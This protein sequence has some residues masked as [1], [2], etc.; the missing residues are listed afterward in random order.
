MKKSIR[1][2]ISLLLT[3]TLL[4]TCLSVP[5][6][7]E[8][9]VSGTPITGLEG[10]YKTQG[11]TPIVGDTLMLDWTASGIEWEAN[12]SGDVKVTLNAT[13]MGHTDVDADGGL[14]FTVYVD[15]VMQAADLRMPETV[16]SIWTSN[17]TDYPFHITALGDTTFTIA[18]GL[19]EGK[20]TFAIY[21]QTEANMGAFGV[22]SIDLT[23]EFLDAPAD[24]E[25]YVEFVGDSITAGH[26]VL[27]NFDVNAPLYEDATRG[28]P[29]LT[30]KALGADW[31][32]LAV[33]G[34]TAID[35]I[36][37][38]G[39]GSVSMQDVYPY[40]IYYSDKTTTHDFANSREPDVIVL[41][42]GTNDCWTWNGTGGVTLTDDQKVT[43][44][45]TML[46]HLRDRNPNAK[47]VWVYG[48]MSSAADSYI[49]QAVSEMGGVGNGYYTLGLEKNT[50]GGRG[51]PNLAVQTTYAADVSSFITKITTPVEQEDWEVPTEKPAYI[52][53]GTSAD[54]YLITNGAE[55]YWAVTNEN[56]GVYFK[57]ANDIILNEMTVDAANGLVSSDVALKEW[58]TDGDDGV[59]F[60]GTIDGD[61]H[62]IKGLYIDHEYTGTTKEWNMGYGLISHANGAVIKNL[63]IESAYVKVVGGAAAAFVGSI[64]NNVGN[65]S[66]ENCYV[67][68][69]VY[70]CGN[71]AG[72]FLSSGGGSKL[73]GGVKNCY[74]I[75][76]VVRTN[77]TYNC[78]GI[79]GPIWSMSSSNFVENAY[80]I[81]LLNGMGTVTN[82]TNVFTT[83]EQTGCTSVTAANMQGT[84]GQ[85]N[86]K[87]LSENF[88]MVDSGYPKL[89]TFVG[90]TNGEWSGFRNDGMTGSGT[91]ASP[92]ILKTPEQLAQIIYNGGANYYFRLENDIYLNDPE[93]FDWATGTVDADYTTI[94]W[95]GFTFKGHFDGNGHVVYGLY[96][97]ETTNN[98]EWKGTGDALFPAMSAGSIKNVGVDHSFIQATNNAAAIVGYAGSNAERTIDNC[99]AGAHVTLIGYNAGGIYGSGDAN[100]TITNC[101][102]LATL[103]GGRFGGISGGW[104]SYKYND[105]YTAHKI[106]NCYTTSSKLYHSATSQTNC[107][108]GVSAKGDAA[109]NTYGNL[110][111]AYVR[112]GENFPTLKV[113]TDLPENAPWN[114]FGD[115]SYIVDGAGTEENPY[116]IETAAQLAHVIY[117]NGGKYY[118]LA[119]DIY[120]NDVSDGWLDREDNLSWV[121]SP[122]YNGYGAG[123][124][125][126]SGTLDGDG[127]VVYGLFYPDDTTAYAGSL[128]PLMGSG[129][130]KNIGVKNSY[131]VARDTASG[132]VG[133][134]RPGSM[135]TVENCFADDTVSAKWTDSSMNGGAAGIVGYTSNGASAH[136]VTIKNCWSAASLTSA[137]DHT[138][139][140]NGIIGKSWVAYY[141]IENCYSIGYKPF[142]INSEKTISALGVSAYKG[143]YTDS[144]TVPYTAGTYTNLTTAQM[145]GKDALTAMSGL[146]GDT[147]YAVDGKTPYLRSYGIT[148]GDVD[149]DGAYNKESDIVALRKGI[150]GVVSAKNGDTDKNGTVDICDLVKFNN[151]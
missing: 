29:Y 138:F 42:L 53:S 41:G 83:V 135:K 48:M 9:T 64:G 109:I 149:E 70:L 125:Y 62:V 131:I 88:C 78:G 54:P 50:A 79:Y 127:Y 111:D 45:K 43:G 46:T 123:D 142:G 137:K 55:L 18:T 3:I 51:H 66:F 76:T 130:V 117:N 86:L 84:A 33:S 40:E 58:N 35:G 116:I 25:L 72:G 87:K 32:V 73:T 38:G 59:Y 103:N 89:K 99:F 139:R 107:Y 68:S 71:Q 144:T 143:V 47:I 6:Y 81:G 100:M 19:S 37:W 44:F 8:T 80:C 145:T 93:K 147:W 129:T 94:G 36:G 57:L 15:G 23:G 22:K 4:G 105:V 24:N 14:Y 97:K 120:L 34:I 108:W 61:N 21:N 11:R 102:S 74:S 2:L 106:N 26:G 148:L 92:Y 128:I 151:K 75:A 20:H 104:W 1:I 69:D 119:N 136:D 30:A 95:Y 91:E 140:S 63:G 52:G 98:D 124:K 85:L 5:L 114:G 39:A 10:K 65:V 96:V 118:K 12:C 101:Y 16:D 28:W 121:T 7:A 77:T 141:T 122:D 49:I 126:F 115:S 146:S 134:M 60:K 17:S 56:S 150:I 13:R 132:I 113:F 67:G 112:I 82:K 31:S 110:G 90:R 27:N 133:I